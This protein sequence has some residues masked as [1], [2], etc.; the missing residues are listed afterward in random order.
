MFVTP[1][2]VMGLIKDGRVRALAFT[3][4]KPF[5]P[6]PDVPLMKSV[7]PGFEQ[8][9]WGV[10][11]APAKTPPDIVAKLNAAIRQALQTPAVAGI[12]QRDGYIPDNRDVAATTAFFH[13]EVKATEEAVKAAGIEPN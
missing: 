11:L 12:I 7:L 4:S 6:F 2:S 13:K 10:F 5:P 3:G 8:G 1:P 9:S